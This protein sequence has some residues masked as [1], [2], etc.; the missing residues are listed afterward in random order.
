MNKP[1]IVRNNGIYKAGLALL[2]LGLI[3][4]LVQ[5]TAGGGRTT[6][7]AGSFNLLHFSLS[8]GSGTWT[9]GGGYTAAG[10]LGQSDSGTATGGSFTL[11]GG[12]IPRAE[13]TSSKLYLPILTRQ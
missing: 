6:D 12:V 11:A 1:R 13:D 10:A 8:A 2:L 4:I 7:L 9:A 5:G 3:L